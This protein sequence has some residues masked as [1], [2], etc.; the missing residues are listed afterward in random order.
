MT[1]GMD[2]FIKNYLNWHKF[3]KQNAMR[4][5]ELHQLF[6]EWNLF[7]WESFKLLLRFWLK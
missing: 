2:F 4:I 7:I 1:K 3:S 6:S 5:I